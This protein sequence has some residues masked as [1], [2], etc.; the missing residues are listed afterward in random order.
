MFQTMVIRDLTLNAVQ[1]A[2]WRAV[3][4]MTGDESRRES[5]ISNVTEIFNMTGIGEISNVTSE[6]AQVIMSDTGTNINGLMWAL[7]IA[8]SILAM[9]CIFCSIRFF[10]QFVTNPPP[11]AGAS[12]KSGTQTVSATSLCSDW[13]QREQPPPASAR[14]HGSSFSV[15]TSARKV[16]AGKALSMKIKSN[17][18]SAYGRPSVTPHSSLS[19]YADREPAGQKAGGSLFAVQVDAMADV[20]VTGKGSFV[21]RDTFSSLVL[22]AALPQSPDGSRKVQV[23]LGESATT[24]CAIVEPPPPGSQAV[25]NSLDIRGDNNVHLG[26]LVLQSTGSFVIYAKPQPELVIEGSEADVDLN[27]FT[28]DRSPKA[29]VSCRQSRPGGPEQVEIH[30]LPGTDSVLVVACI[31]AIL[32]L[33]GET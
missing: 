1:V 6:L 15:P 3:D 30:V 32:F 25:P 31:L 9:G 24:P 2:T 21:I 27:V 22:R 12:R 20:N 14:S 23:F 10:E 29:T 33:C 4:K 17:G 5:E 18:S 8:V 7:V 16:H 28:R 26:S 13:P 19:M 11:R